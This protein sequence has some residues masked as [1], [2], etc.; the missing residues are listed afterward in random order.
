MDTNT[1][2][3]SV[4]PVAPKS[5][6]SLAQSARGGHLKAARGILIGVGL[7]TLVV[8]G[9]LLFNIENEVHQVIQ[10]AIQQNQIDPADAPQYEQ[11]IRIEGYLIRGGPALMGLI[12]VIFGLI[13]NKFP[14]AITT[15]SLILYL[16]TILGLALHEPAS[17]ARG[18]VL[19]IIIIAALARSIK[20]AW[21]YEAE[22]KKAATLAGAEA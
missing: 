11:A 7:L 1:I 22:R 14:V 21:A 18:P 5:L 3:E 4:P 9:F 13:I 6:G 17:L 19:K 10:Q 15:T 12:F 20:A 2:D 16:A 8:N